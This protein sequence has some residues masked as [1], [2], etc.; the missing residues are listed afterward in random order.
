MESSDLE[1]L[2]REQ[3]ISRD[4]LAKYKG[5]AEVSIA[6]LDFLHLCRQIDR[7]VIERLKRDFEG[8]GCIKDEYRILAIIED[9]IL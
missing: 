1:F 3:R 8:E 4:K 9:S 5:L 2:T 7:K 6:H